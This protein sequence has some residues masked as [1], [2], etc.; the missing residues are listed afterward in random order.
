VQ[1][2]D[3][4]TFSIYIKPEVPCYCYVIVQDAEKNDAVL[5][6]GKLQAGQELDLGPLEITPPSGTETFYIV[7]TGTQQAQFEGSHTGGEIIN[8]VLNFRR[9]IS[10]LKENPE[11]PVSMGGAFRGTGTPPLRP[12]GIQYSG[13]DRYVKT[14]IIR[15]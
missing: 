11:K 13:A 14:I 9:A 10:Q 5:Q 4:D 12:K 2:K 3:N 15:H 8:A 7:M 1:L 6:S